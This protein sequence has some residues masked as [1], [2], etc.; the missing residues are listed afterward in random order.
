MVVLYSACDGKGEI[1]TYLRSSSHPSIK[2]SV[3][4]APTCPNISL[5]ASCRNFWLCWSS[6]AWAVDE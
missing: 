1:Y 5:L 2:G 3:G 4:R 6:S